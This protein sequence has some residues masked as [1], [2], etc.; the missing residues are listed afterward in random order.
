[1]VAELGLGGVATGIDMGRFGVNCDTGAWLGFINLDSWFNCRI[2]GLGCLAG[3][4]RQWV[5][6]MVDF[7]WDG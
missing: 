3:D 6:E 4:S 5:S 1:M 7:A 2:N